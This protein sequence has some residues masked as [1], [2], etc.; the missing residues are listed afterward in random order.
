MFKRARAFDMGTLL[1][2][3]EAERASPTPHWTWRGAA[4]NACAGSLIALRRCTSRRPEALG[5]EPCAVDGTRAPASGQTARVRQK[6]VSC[7][8]PAPAPHG[9]T[10]Y[11]EPPR[12]VGR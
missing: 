10:G 4:W 8:S 7:P 12:C 1:Q 3:E 2:Q 9:P 6:A 5:P 11:V